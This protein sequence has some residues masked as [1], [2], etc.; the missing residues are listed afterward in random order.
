MEK[1]DNLENVNDFDIN[2]S[3]GVLSVTFNNNT[4]VINRQIPNQQIWYSSPVRFIK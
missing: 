3:E 2:Y 4:F 1:L